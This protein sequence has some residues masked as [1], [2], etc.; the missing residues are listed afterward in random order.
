[1]VLGYCTNV[2]AGRDW[3][4]TRAN[5]EAHAAMVKAAVSPNGVLPVGLW[6]SHATLGQ[7]TQQHRETELA[8]L[9]RRLGLDAFTFNGFP[10][11]DFHTA[12][13]KHAVYEPAWDTA[14]RV[15]FT[16]GLARLHALLAQGPCERSI[17]TLPLGWG[18]PNR[19]LADLDEAVF[20]LREVV[21][22]LAQLHDET[23]VLVHVDIEPEP[24]C[25]V[26]TSR[27]VIGLFE[28]MVRGVDNEEKLR[29]HVRVCHDVCHAAVMFEEQGAVLA[30]Y[31]AAGIRVGKVQISNALRVDLRGLSE[32]ERSD[33]LANLQ[34][35]AEDRYLHQTVIAE[36]DERTFFEDLPLALEHLASRDRAGDEWRVH[37]HVPVF[38]DRVGELQTTQ[39][40][41]RQCL[42]AIQPSDEVNH[43]EVETY[44]WEVLPQ[45]MQEMQLA[46]GIARELQWVKGEL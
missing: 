25:I 45:Q 32:R 24:G 34:P 35:F 30:R 13:V 7:L 20:N 11:G 14:A 6:L 40:A 4:Q 29:R 33:A 12:S 26:E 1:M 27:D 38:L 3:N 39:Q 2:H 5:L 9:L 21:S 18:D 36:N 37:Y 46:E 31:R 19:A 23:G 28:R 44:T 10:F 8:E 15:A 41:I 43:F 16:L 17:S 42:D 22:Q